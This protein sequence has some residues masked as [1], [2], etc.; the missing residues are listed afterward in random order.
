MKRFGQYQKFR[1]V[2]NEVH[3]Y[4]NAKTIRY[5]V[6]DNMW[7]NAAIQKALDALEGFQDVNKIKTMG[8]AGCWEGRNVQIDVI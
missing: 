5:G 6:G 7:V 1:I 4:A 2:I 8:L 3:F